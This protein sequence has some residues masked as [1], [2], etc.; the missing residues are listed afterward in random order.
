MSLTQQL[1]VRALIAHFWEKPL[2][3]GRKLMSWGTALHDRF[4]LPYF[5]ER[6]LE[7]VLEELNDAGYPFRKEWFAPHFEF[8][9][10]A[11]GSITKRG[12]H[13]ELRGMRWSPGTCW[14]KRRRPAARRATWIPRWSECR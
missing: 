7:D 14:A 11:I 3:S 4:M 12:I 2:T 1:L 5:V 6:D 8:R 10:P 9:F 13:L